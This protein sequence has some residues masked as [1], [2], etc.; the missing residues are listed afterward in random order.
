M[1]GKGENHWLLIQRNCLSDERWDEAVRLAP[2][3][4]LYATT[5]W[6]D[7]M[8][9]ARW[10]AWVWGD[11]EMVFPVYA[12]RKLWIPYITQPVLCQRLGLFG[13][14]PDPLVQK[15]LFSQLFRKN[16]KAD[17]MSQTELPAPYSGVERVNHILA[18]DAPYNVVFAHYHRNARRN[19]E[20]ARHSGVEIFKEE[21]HPVIVPFFIQHDS[22]GLISLWREK[23]LA[24]MEAFRGRGG[25]AWV[26]RLGEELLA[27]A[28]CV[29][30][31]DRVYFL[32]CQSSQA[33]KQTAAMY[34]LIDQMVQYYAGGAYKWFDF[35]GSNLSSVARRNLS[36]GAVE[37]TYWH[38]NS[39]WFGVLR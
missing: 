20:K 28:Y 36:L 23:L 30:Y 13:R 14:N 1:I 18:I 21:D 5:A 31:E 33:G 15:Q 11:Y 6:L 7:A 17:L 24:A 26:A 22:T 9:S 34:L 4:I 2:T 8:T 16:W 27:A 25:D 35:T 12:K 19:I 38:V 37:E 3:P 29:C 10:S 39:R 32:L